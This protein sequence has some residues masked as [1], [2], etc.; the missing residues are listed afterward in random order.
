MAEGGA[1]IV[2]LVALSMVFYGMSMIISR[3]YPLHH[4]TK[5]SGTIWTFAAIFNVIT[6]FLL[7]PVIGIIGAAITTLISRIFAFV[8]ILGIGRKYLPHLSLPP[9]W[10]TAKS[11]TASGMMLVMLFLVNNLV[12]LEPLFMILVLVPLGIG[13]YISLMWIF[14][15]FRENEIDFIRQLLRGGVS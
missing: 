3:V 4:D 14:R 12:N 11:V 6:N 5:T 7:V 8:L 1:P 9:L 15:C 2:P 13:I 10:F